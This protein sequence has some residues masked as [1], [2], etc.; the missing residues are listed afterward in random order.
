M[1]HDAPIHQIHGRFYSHERLRKISRG[2]EVGRLSKGR[3]VT[4]TVQVA[5]GYRGGAITESKK[6]TDNV[7]IQAVCEEVTF[8]LTSKRSTSSV[9]ALVKESVTTA[10]E[11]RRQLVVGFLDTR[12]CFGSIHLHDWKRIMYLLEWMDGASPVNPRR[13]DGRVETPELLNEA[14]QW[15]L[16]SAI[17]ECRRHSRGCKYA[18]EGD[19]E[20]DKTE[21]ITI[22][23]WADTVFLFASA[24]E[25]MQLMVWDFSDA[26]YEKQRMRWNPSSLEVMYAATLKEEDRRVIVIQDSDTFLRTLFSGIFHSSLAQQFLMALHQSVGTQGQA[27]PSWPARSKL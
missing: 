19:T 4:Y 11:W 7:G 17:L 27:H 26:L 5:V 6:T 12:T 1:W 22:L 15:A 25:E 3:V 18:A 10:R 9:T 16:T 8:G 14:L 21:R 24:A 13:E 2:K 20:D 23:I